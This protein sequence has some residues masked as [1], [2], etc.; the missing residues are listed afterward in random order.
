MIRE[1]AR[2]AGHEWLWSSEQL[3]SALFI[4]CAAGQPLCGERYGLAMNRKHAIIFATRLAACK[5]AS[6][7]R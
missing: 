4:A 3:A 5:L 7:P 1:K 6:N 2:S